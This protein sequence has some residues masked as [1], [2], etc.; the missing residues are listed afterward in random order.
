MPEN[1][2]TTD[3]YTSAGRTEP[4][5]VEPY[6]REWGIGISGNRAFDT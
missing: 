6:D 1:A 4:Y 5:A 2:T 3:A